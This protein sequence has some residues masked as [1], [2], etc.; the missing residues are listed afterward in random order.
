MDEGTLSQENEKKQLNQ[1]VQTQ[2][3]VIPCILEINY[4]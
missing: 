3:G 4:A 2:N 1:E